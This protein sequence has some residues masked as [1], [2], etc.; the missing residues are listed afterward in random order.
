M[1]GKAKKA[2]QNHW[3]GSWY[4]TLHLVIPQQILAFSFS[5]C[6][7]CSRCRGGPKA[8]EKC[9][10]A[11]S[12]LVLLYNQ[13][14]EGL[15]GACKNDRTVFDFYAALPGMKMQFIKYCKV[16]ETRLRSLVTSPRV[17]PVVE[18]DP[19][20]MSIPGFLPDWKS[21]KPKAV[22]LKVELQF[23]EHH[24]KLYVDLHR[25]LIKTDYS[26]QSEAALQNFKT[27][28]LLDISL[29]MGCDIEWAAPAP[30]I[31]GGGANEAAILTSSAPDDDRDASG[32][33]NCGGSAG[34]RDMASAAEEAAS[35]AAA[36]VAAAAEA[37]VAAACADAA[38]AAAPAGGDAAPAC[39]AAASVSDSED[40]V[41]DVNDFTTWTPGNWK[42]VEFDKISF[43]KDHNVSICSVRSYMAVAMLL[44]FDTDLRA[45][46]TRLWNELTL[47]WKATFH[48]DLDLP[49]LERWPKGDHPH[50]FTQEQSDWLE[51]TLRYLKRGPGRLSSRR[52]QQTAP[53]LVSKPATAVSWSSVKQD[54]G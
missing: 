54:G 40:D 36:I 5:E 1:A 39:G 8:N 4:V 3:I 15:F 44:W 45:T 32:D 10:V 47:C 13:A 23:L 20:D 38:A 11:I 2:S 29:L 31:S 53:A 16:F 34:T 51:G 46:Q 21:K 7:F 49:G 42:R 17:I 18:D 6:W 52:R 25:E 48:S 22:S 43:P 9:P 41:P 35:A 26:P 33:D 27:L 12:D 14:Q 24:K 50:A 37:S 30:S 19:T 28:M